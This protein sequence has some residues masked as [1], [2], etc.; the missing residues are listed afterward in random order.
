M[1]GHLGLRVT[2]CV[3]VVENG[4]QDPAFYSLD[5]KSSKENHF[6]CCWAGDTP[7]SQNLGRESSLEPL[8]KALRHFS[9][10]MCVWHSS[11]RGVLGKLGLNRSCVKSLTCRPLQFDLSF[12]GPLRDRCCSG[13]EVGPMSL[14]W[15]LG[16]AWQ[17]PLGPWPAFRIA[18][19]VPGSRAQ[20]P[21]ASCGCHTHARPQMFEWGHQG[22]AVA[23]AQGSPL[24]WGHIL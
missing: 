13:F 1:P 12:L 3:S 11:V 21:R 19:C 16:N 23:A 8:T 14:V 20:L 15:P 17:L 7:L 10:C 22:G 5:P 9:V 24:P 4:N 2:C 6:P 18:L